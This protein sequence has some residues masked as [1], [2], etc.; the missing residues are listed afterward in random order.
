MCVCVCVRVC[1]C[2]CMHV[3]DS[4]VQRERERTNFKGFVG[5]EYVVDQRPQES[6]QMVAAHRKCVLTQQFGSDGVATEEIR[7]TRF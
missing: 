7:G 1:V 3:S 2:V 4:S 5:L 6:H